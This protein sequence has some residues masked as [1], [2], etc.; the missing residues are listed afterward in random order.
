MSILELTNLKKSFGSRPAVDGVSLSVREGEI[1]GILGPNGAG[2][3]TTLSM[4][5]GLIKSSSGSITVDGWDTIKNGPKAKESIG[6]V[7]QEPALYPQ[8]SAKAN[9]NFWGTL[10]GI[11]KENLAAAVADALALVGLEDRADEAIKKYS[12]GMKRR[13]NIA[14]GLVHKPR[15]LIMDEPTVG[16]DP[17]SRSHI[18]ETVKRLKDQGTTIIY[19]SHYVEEVEYLCERVAIMDHGKIIAVGTIPELLSK[20]E[21][22]QELVVTLTQSADISQSSISNLP[23][24]KEAISLDKNLRIIT[25]NAEQVLPLAFETLVNKGVQVSEIKIHKPNL[26]SLFLKLTGRALR[27]Q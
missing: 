25:A 9:L 20:A 15:L 7:P 5:C 22:Y 2:K 4:I 26:E 8:L 21:Q 17:Q 27:D 1:F 6:I 3:S 11:K 23:G 24:V 16:V 14:A 13:L 19:T 10:N 18:L 12:G